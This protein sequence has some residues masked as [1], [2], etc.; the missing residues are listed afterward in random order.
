MVSIH[1]STFFLY[2][3]K[4]L[5]LLKISD[6]R[7]R[8]WETSSR[9]AANAVTQV[10]LSQTEVLQTHCSSLCEETVHNADRGFFSRK[11]L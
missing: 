11:K 8:L 5:E 10:Y 6:R 3:T 2:T 4:K 9:L 1:I 7:P